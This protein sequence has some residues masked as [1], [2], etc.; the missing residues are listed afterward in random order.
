M[1]EPRHLSGEALY[2]DDFSPQEIERW[3]ADE[4]EAYFEMSGGSLEPGRYGYLELNR[5][6][7]LRFL[8]PGRRFRHALGFGSGYGAEL[9][10]LASRIDRLTIVESS[11]GY[12]RDPR[13]AM[14]VASLPAVPSGDIGLPDAS[15]DLISCIGV[16]H[17]IPNVTHVV[18]EFARVL[19]P[20]GVLLLREPVTSMGGGW[21]RPRPGL[22]PHE[23]GIPRALLRAG[24]EGAGFAIEHE[25]LVIFPAILRLWRYAGRPP[26]NS[27]WLTRL[28][29]RISRALAWNLR[30]H[31]TRPWQ[32]V[33]PGEVSVVARR[34]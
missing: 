25:E 34:T 10:P 6:S 27:P 26:Y 2:G 23:R 30:Y 18:G 32:K 3:F 4:A 14:P 31:A 33:R 5:Q 1:S 28:D 29:R 19:E 22:T 17:H 12:G 7:L 9:V 11:G 20:G 15:V 8:E 24:L 13:L 16:L 21:G